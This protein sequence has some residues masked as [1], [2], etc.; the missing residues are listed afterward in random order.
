VGAV[1][2]DAKIPV[3]EIAQRLGRH[4]ATINRELSRKRFIDAELQD[5]SGYYPLTAQSKA[6][7]RRTGL[8]K[9]VRY[10]DLREIVVDRLN[11]GW[12]PE[13]IAVR[14]RVEGSDLLVSHETIYRFAYSREGHAIDLWRHL[15]EHRRRRRGRGK[16]RSQAHK[17][18]DELSIRHRPEAIGTR[19]EF[20]NWEGDLIQFEKSSVAPMSPPWSSGSAASPSF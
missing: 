12:T 6:E 2:H 19:E 13:Q 1:Q 7:T 15:P 11:T 20:G 18:S 14:L 4:R 3:L 9:L 5:L 10:R 8:R 16:Q 17:F